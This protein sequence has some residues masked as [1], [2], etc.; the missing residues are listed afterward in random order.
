MNQLSQL[1]KIISTQKLQGK[2]FLVMAHRFSCDEGHIYPVGIYKSVES[3]HRCIERTMNGRAAK[4]GV[5]VYVSLPQEPN[6]NDEA[7]MKLIYEVDSVYKGRLKSTT[8]HSATTTKSGCEHPLHNRQKGNRCGN[9]GE[10]LPR[11]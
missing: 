3:I 1:R 2:S 7:R 6:N 8:Q 11:V 10:F 4:Y 9:C 5:K